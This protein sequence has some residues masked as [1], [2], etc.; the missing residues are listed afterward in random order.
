MFSGN[1]LWVLKA[2]LVLAATVLGLSVT[3]EVHA[4]PF[5]AHPILDEEMYIEWARRIAGG[6]WV[7]K[8]AFY[9][10]PLYAYFLAVLLKVFSGS[11]LLARLVQVGLWAGTVALVI[12]TGERL[13][14]KAP[15]LVAGLLL[16][17]FGPGYF[18]SSFLLKEGLIMH[19][20]AWGCWATA[21]AMD[22]G[23]R[24]RS[25]LVAPGVV[26]GLS[27][28]L[29]G[30]FL[31][32][33]PLALLWPLWMLRGRSAVFKAGAVAAVAAGVLLP[34]SVS[35]AHNVVAAGQWMPTTTQGGPNF[36]IG[37]NPYANGSYTVPAFVR[38]SPR[39]EITDFQVE[40]ER[41]VGRTVTRREVSDYWLGEGLRFWKES[42]GAAVGLLLRKVQLLTNA[43]EIPDNYGFECVREYF[44]P[45]LWFAF[46]NFGWLLGPALLGMFLAL[47]T[48]RR[49]IPLVVLAVVYGGSVVL[50]FVMDRYRV[51]LIPLECLFAGHFGVL[52]VGWARQRRWR[53]LGLHTLAAALVS[54]SAFLPTPLT[55]RRPSQFARC[56][57][58]AGTTLVENGQASTAIPLLTRA[59]ELAPDQNDADYNL[60]WALQVDGR[61]SDAKVAYER[62][63]ERQPTHAQARFNLGLILLEQHQPSKAAFQLEAARGD[64]L[65]TAQLYGALSVAYGATAR[66]DQALDASEQALRLDGASVRLRAGFIDASAQLGRCAEA[67]RLL[68]ET[69]E[70]AGDARALLG[71]CFTPPP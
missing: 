34:L 39:Y 26:L 16:T 7:G 45:T 3:L 59:A 42:P 15:G 12:E 10:D 14:G 4:S 6:E 67:K 69:P 47:R 22:E 35:T 63:L 30:N 29:R 13:F 27:C 46:L 24:R 31:L 60:G 71:S 2:L 52:A 53:A 70:L 41:R 66:W 55:A 18:Q 5:G 28:L 1:R 58:L 49:S 57:H 37:N 50:F 65:A 38:P 32:V 51:P 56:L 54:A 11:L 62:A 40:F 19:L 8:D 48:E 61:L 64:G 44:A 43:H 21:R 23:E 33:V 25:V 20:V 17:L 9:F 36:F 68:S